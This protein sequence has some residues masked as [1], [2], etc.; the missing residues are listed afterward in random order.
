MRVP[1]APLA[2][3]SAALVVLAA[4]VGCAGSGLAPTTGPDAVPSQRLMASTADSLAGATGY[5]ARRA[6]TERLLA[7]F[8]VTPLGDMGRQRAANPRFAVEAGRT[9]A[10]LVGGL[11]PG[12]NPVA[13]PELVI[14]GASLDGPDVGPLLEAARVMAE[15]SEW[16]VV[17]E[18][19]VM[20]ALWSGPDGVRDALSS[21]VWPQA[22]VRA[23]LVVGAPVAVPDTTAGGVR[24]V[25]A[26]IPTAS[27]EGTPG[28]DTALAQRIVDET[29]RL[30]R[31][32]A[33]AD[34]LATTTR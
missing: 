18:R 32:A 17:P 11:L 26:T 22:N 4:V 12:R 6:L 9:R 23:V 30:A 20:V 31:R 2:L 15:R 16:A 7:R 33:P 27:R 34:T 29:L 3:R 14:I 25:M 28:G 21:G 19:T 1:L 24:L 5:A 8:G 13:R 10:P